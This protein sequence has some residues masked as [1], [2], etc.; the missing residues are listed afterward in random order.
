[1]PLVLPFGRGDTSH[2]WPTGAG[3]GVR[4]TFLK[5]IWLVLV[6]PVLAATIMPVL[7]VTFC[8]VEVGL[9]DGVIVILIFQKCPIRA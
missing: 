9:F 3:G 4:S 8:L 7:D 2:S 6:V 5:T 1:V